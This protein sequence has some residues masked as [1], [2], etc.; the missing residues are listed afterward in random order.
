MIDAAWNYIY[1]TFD[2]SQIIMLTF[3]VLLLS[4]IP[5]FFFTFLDV[6]QLDCLAKYRI[7]YSKTRKYPTNDDIMKCMIHSYKSVFKIY[8][9]MIIVGAKACQFIDWYPYTISKELPTF[10]LGLLE[11][12][13]ISIFG[14]L[15]FYWAHRLFHIPY[16]YQKY[17]K[18]HH[19][20]QF[21]H[22]MVPHY[23]HEVETIF[24]ILPAVIP[25]ISFGS[26]IVIVWAWI[27]Y[28][29][30]NGVI[31]HCGYYLPLPYWIY[32][33]MPTFRT[34]YHDAHHYLFHKNFGLLYPW[35][36]QLFGTYQ[37]PKNVKYI[38][39]TSLK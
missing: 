37:L 5:A 33:W 22:A 35:I 9:T 3:A 23:I 38:D 7:N 2:D 8:G 26:H 13:I 19:S 14:D 6:L 28:A 16:L 34:E 4:E 39:G 36:D 1:A 11:L 18:L 17:H 24:F 25:P 31:G 21:T 29:Q 20:Y 27:V 32:K 10:W 12:F 15:L 30:L